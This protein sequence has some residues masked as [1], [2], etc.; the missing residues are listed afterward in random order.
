MKK[1]ICLMIALV[2]CA[3]LLA[4]CGNETKDPV[5]TELSKT[6]GTKSQINTTAS[7]NPSPSDTEKAGG[8][9]TASEPE[10]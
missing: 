10:T 4:G 9:A 2:F 8:T 1:I 3:S 6:E 5:N 7:E